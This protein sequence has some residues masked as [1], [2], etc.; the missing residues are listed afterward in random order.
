VRLRRRQV[1][2]W[3]GQAVDL[4]APEESQEPAAVGRAPWILAASSRTAAAVELFRSS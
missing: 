3:L 2:A 4:P 1:E